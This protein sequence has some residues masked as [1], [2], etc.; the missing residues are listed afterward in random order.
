MPC[1]HPLSL[2]AAAGQPTRKPHHPVFASH[3]HDPSP[4]LP[5]PAGRKLMQG[6]AACCLIDQSNAPSG[7]T[8]EQVCSVC[9][10][11]MCLRVHVR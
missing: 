6:N 5:S 1:P 4:P 11:Q 8:C 7:I 10:G 3:Q 2:D 9:Y